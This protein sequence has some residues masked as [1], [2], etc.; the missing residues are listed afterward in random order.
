M[1]QHL[2]N[3]RSYSHGKEITDADILYWAN[4][5]VKNSGRRSRIE[6]FKVSGIL[7][8]SPHLMSEFLSN[9]GLS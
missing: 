6:S 7:S 4:N 9:F 5:K 3:L 8:F 1:L 2:K